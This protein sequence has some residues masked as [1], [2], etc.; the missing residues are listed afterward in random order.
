MAFN[1]IV[2]IAK[3]QAETG[4]T[5]TSFVHKNSGPAASN[6]AL[7]VDTSMGA[8]TPKY[9]AYVG[10]QY[11]STPLIGAG[12]FGIYTGGDQDDDKYLSEILLQST[13]ASH[14]LSTYILCDYLMFYPLVDMDSTD[15][16]DMDNVAPL[17][18]YADGAGVRIMAVVTTPVS[19]FGTVTI[20]YTNQ[21][22][23][24]S[25][26][27]TF[28]P[29]GFAVAVGNISHGVTSN[30]VASS[31]P[32]VTLQSGDTGVRSIESITNSSPPGGFMAFVLVKPLATVGLTEAT[33][34][35][36]TNF[37]KDK[38]TMPR[39]YN[40]AYLGF[41]SGGTI[42]V[43]GIFRAALTFIWG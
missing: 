38:V 2:D 23:V 21:D 24:G 37:I 43:S 41:V 11:E 35:T 29:T 31:H 27:A 22:G 1:R 17:P 19:T 5:W 18:R 13:V 42:R 26:T 12:N 30:Q 40:G 4:A 32:F 36:E 20:T 33:T 6:A 7:W 28:Y 8:G 9:N 3:A 34:A 10:A 25:R 39:I 15:Q 14:S 16:Q